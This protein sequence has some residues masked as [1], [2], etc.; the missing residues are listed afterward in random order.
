[1]LEAISAILYQYIMVWSYLTALLM[2][3][4]HSF[5][6]FHI[7]Y[8]FNDIRYSAKTLQINFAKYDSNQQYTYWSVMDHVGPQNTPEKLFIENLLVS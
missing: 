5:V 7:D 3:Q 1:M 6:I 4:H 8:L 2:Y